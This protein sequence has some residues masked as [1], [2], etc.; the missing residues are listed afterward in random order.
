M[1]SNRIPYFDFYPTDFMR[2]VR[3]L[4]AAEVGVYTML[5]CRIYEENGPVEYHPVRLSAYC[6]VRESVLTKAVDRLIVLGRLEIENGMLS[7]DRAV[8]EI[9]IRETKLKNSSRAGK[10]SAEKRQQKQEQS[11]T[12]VQQTFNHTDTDTEEE[13]KE[14]TNVSL[15]ADHQPID[16]VAEAVHAYKATAAQK[17]WPIPQQLDQ[18]R[19]RAISGRIRDAG[20]VE[21]W[22]IAIDKAAGSEFLGQAR[23]FSGFGIDWIAKPANF[24]K[25]MEGNYDGQPS[26]RGNFHARPAVHSSDR[27]IAFAARAVRT[28]SSDCI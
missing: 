14:D 12:P 25:I 19:R 13:K 7:D 9:T 1:S 24:K 26:A 17:G 22:R 10:A 16:E 4:T 21:G 20:G 2:G 28:P 15:A 11:A 18:T 5:L 27:Q 3:G 6:G 8:K 23:P